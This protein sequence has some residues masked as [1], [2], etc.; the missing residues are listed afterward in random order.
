MTRAEHDPIHRPAHYTQSA[1]EPIDAIEA[2]GLG[3]HLGNVVKY[4]ARY[5][6]KG[7]VD[8]LRK[9]RQYLDWEIAALEGAE[10]VLPEDG[11]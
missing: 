5:P 8:D 3:Y 10:A 6:R 7:G 1:V 9:A 2:W 4:V 11:R